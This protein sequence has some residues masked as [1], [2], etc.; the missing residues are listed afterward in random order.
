MLPFADAPD[1]LINLEGALNQAHIVADKFNDY[2]DY[3]TQLRNDIQN[4]IESSV[5]IINGLLNEISQINTQIR[6][7]ENFGRSVAG[8]SDQRDLALKELSDHID[9]SFF[10][11]SDGVLVVQTSDG[12]QLVD[13]QQFIIETDTA[14]LSAN[15]FYPDSIDGIFV[16]CL[17]EHINNPARIDITTRISGGKLGGL[18]ELRDNTIP[19]YQAQLD[20]LAFQTAKRFEDQGLRLFTDQAGN[21][22]TGDPPELNLGPPAGTRTAVDYVGFS[23]EMKV[24]N[25][26]DNDPTLLQRGTYISDEPIPTGDGELIRRVLEFT[27]GETE[28]Q[29]AEGTIDL[30]TLPPGTAD[31]QQLLGLRPTNNIVAGLDLSAFEQIDYGMLS[32]LGAFPTLGILAGSP[33]SPIT[34]AND[35]FEITFEDQSRGLGPITVTIDLL[36]GAGTAEVQVAPDAMRQVIQEI[37]DQ[38]AASG[39]DPLLGA[40]ASLGPQNQ[41]VI[42]TSGTATITTTGIPNAIGDQAATAL[43]IIGQPNYSETSLEFMPGFPNNDAFDIDIGGNL[44][45]IDLSTISTGFPLGGP[46]YIEDGAGGFDPAGPPIANALDQLISFVNSQI[47]G[48]GIPSTPQGPPPGDLVAA[49]A[50]TNEYGQFVLNT[51]EDVTITRTT[52]S[53]EGLEAL[54]FTEGFF[55][56]EDPSFTVQVG[57]NDPVT[58]FIEPGDTAADLVDK[59]ELGVGGLQPG[60]AGLYVDFDDTGPPT[61]NN[62]GTITLRPGIDVDEHAIPPIDPQTVYGGDLSITSGAF[63]TDPTLATHAVI[64]AASGSMNIVS[65]LFG[66]FT[67]DGLG[68]VTDNSPLNSVGYEVETFQNG[69]VGSG[70]FTNFRNDYLGPDAQVETGIFSAFDLVDYAQKIVNKTSSDLAVARSAFENEDTLR[71]IIQRDFSDQSGVNIDEEM[72]HLIV[73]QSAYAAAARTITAVDEMFQE[74]LNAF[75]R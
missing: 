37:N 16:T 23:G 26:I 74:L 52:I 40:S 29:E 13:D 60:V 58:I 65:A 57:T 71:G 6:G 31:L 2:E 51:T 44:I 49:F 69:G 17:D 50:T 43:G 55:A 8:L 72:S 45:S 75:R 48:L 14:P 39:I 67:D 61:G 41:L 33:V 63:D 34:A 73:V 10:E 22:P 5:N 28:Y 66:S 32:Q 54:G 18:I 36:G 20:E 21:V 25:Q 64:G 35:T 30:N 62:T 3:L 1:S 59:L 68:N 24:Y 38:L 12:L 56:N 27:F 15:Q 46:S 70:V 19:Q 47:D 7:A 53:T 9:I 4:D 11:R 42:E